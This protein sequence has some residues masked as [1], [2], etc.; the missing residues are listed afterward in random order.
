MIDSK[1]FNPLYRV[2]LFSHAAEIKKQGNQIMFQSPISGLTFLTV[3]AKGMDALRSKS[4][5]PLYR[6]SLFSRRKVN[7][8]K[9]G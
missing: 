4:F 2:S 5:N 6:V 3:G 8:Q 1:S 9:L 7:M